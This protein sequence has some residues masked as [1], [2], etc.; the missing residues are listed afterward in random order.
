M[1]KNKNIYLVWQDGEDEQYWNQY[2]SL[3]DAVTGE[4]DGAEIF[5]ALPKSIGRYELQ[6]KLKKSKKAKV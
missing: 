3:I 4:P 5:E 2:E 1:N 6:T